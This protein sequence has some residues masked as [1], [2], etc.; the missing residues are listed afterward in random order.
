M[1]SIP[2]KAESKITSAADITITPTTDILVITV[3]ACF[4]FGERRYRFAM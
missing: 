1:D 2:L 3:T 4:F